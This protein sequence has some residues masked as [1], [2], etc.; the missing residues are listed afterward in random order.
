MT[1]G[2]TFSLNFSSKM[3]STSV[4]GWVFLCAS[5][6][7]RVDSNMNCELVLHQ[8]QSIFPSTDLLEFA[9]LFPSQYSKEY[10]RMMAVT[11][12]M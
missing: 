6:T 11:I 8:I 10:E 12:V 1:H 5:V 3:S 2:N 7:I 4:L 9:P